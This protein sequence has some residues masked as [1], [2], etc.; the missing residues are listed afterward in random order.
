VAFALGFVFDNVPTTTHDHHL[1]AQR[2]HFYSAGKSVAF[3]WNTLWL[4]DTP[5]F[6]TLTSWII[7]VYRPESSLAIG[8]GLAFSLSRKRSSLVRYLMLLRKILT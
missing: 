3:G 5:D 4:T 6:Q 1:P 2:K 7:S 8:K